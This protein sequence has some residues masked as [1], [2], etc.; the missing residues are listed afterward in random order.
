MNDLDY[1]KMAMALALKAKGQT[2]P[3]PLVGAVIVKNGKI[4]ASGFHRR[5]GQDHAEIVALKKANAN[6]RGATMY[7]TLEPCGHYGR[8]PPCT[9][10]IIKSGIKKVVAGTKDPNLVNN[11]KSI[12]LLNKKGIKTVVG[13]LKNDLQRMNEV[14][15]KFIQQKMPF[16]VIKCAQTLDGKIATAAGSSKWV[17]SAATRIFSHKLRDEFDGILVGVTTVIKDNPCLCGLK[18]Q[19][20]LKKIILD[21]KL[22]TPFSAKLFKGVDFGQVIIVTSSK[23]D[24]EKICKFEKKGVVVLRCP[25]AGDSFDLKWLF[26]QLAAKEITSILVEGGSRTIGKILKSKLA[27]KALIFI[28]PK[29][30]G[31]Q[32]ALSAVDGL[33]IQDINNALSLNNVSVRRI[34]ED[35]FIEGYL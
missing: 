2:S 23:A 13:I 24:A 27:D 4:I 3:N 9:E 21:P 18:L 26:K 11:G 34:G 22:R 20:T 14:F 12:R 6:V 15:F 17:T 33:K 25:M 29:I 8:T 28:A 16:V 7:V 5:C 32:Q 19:K 31:D 10:A 35:I 1:M 30:I